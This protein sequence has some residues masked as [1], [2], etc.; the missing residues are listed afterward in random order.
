[1]KTF[2]FLLVGKTYLID[3]FS[4]PSAKLTKET[5][6][7]EHAKL[8][9]T[10]TAPPPPAKNTKR[11]MHKKR[12]LVLHNSKKLFLKFFPK[13]FP[14]LREFNPHSGL[15]ISIILYTHTHNT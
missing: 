7:I 3:S 2:F 9:D 4:F 1:M 12:I 13:Y 5:Y 14:P 11:Y 10:V 6:F 8:V 15:N